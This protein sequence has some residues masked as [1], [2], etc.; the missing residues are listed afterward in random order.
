MGVVSEMK[1]DDHELVGPSENNDEASSDTSKAKE[2]A[3]LLAR[4]QAQFGDMDVGGLLDGNDND[5]GKC[6]CEDDESESSLDEPTAEELIAWQ[7]AQYA[8]GRMKLETKK[9]MEGGSSTSIQKSA[10]QRRRQNKTVQER[11]LMREYE[12][13]EESNEWE[14]V[15]PTPALDGVTSI[16]FP[17]ALESD[18]EDTGVLELVGG[19]NPLLQKLAKGDPDVL[20]TKW[21]RL[22]S[23]TDGDGLSFRNLCSKI[24]GYDGPTVLLVGG[25][26]SASRCVGQNNGDRVSLGFFTTD[27]WIESPDYFGS[28]DDCFLFSLDHKTNHVQFVRPKAR[29]ESPSNVGSKRYMYCHPSSLATANRAKTN[30]SVHGIGIGGTASQPRMHITESLEECRALG[31]DKLFEDG[32]LLSGKCSQSLFYF[33][34]DCIEV[35]GV[36]GKEWIACAKEAQAK[37]KEA[38]AVSLEQARKVDKSQFLEDFQNGPLQPGLF[39]HRSLV[40]ERCDL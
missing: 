28:D 30:G 15:D 3:E 24:T 2:E 33:D 6:N 19:V 31:Y 7:E 22:Y 25:T 16:F 20:G 14:H 21:S 36:G 12:E 13:N 5:G 35:F 29:S 38:H 11:T 40:E 9:I 4:L 34:V 37:E 32:D 23:S 10:L 17:N 1:D 39:G 26:P 8:K 27:T 18:D